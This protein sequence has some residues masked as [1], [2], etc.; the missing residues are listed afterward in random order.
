MAEMSR[1]ASEEIE[2]AYNV[3]WN[4]YWHRKC[5]AEWAGV[6]WVYKEYAYEKINLLKKF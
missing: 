3:V 1:A 6:E 2:G 4:V 5:G